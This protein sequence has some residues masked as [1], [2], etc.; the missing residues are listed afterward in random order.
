M[1][2][3]PDDEIE[4]YRDHA[5]ECAAY[6][7]FDRPDEAPW[8]RGDRYGWRRE[9][10]AW[11]HLEK[12][13]TVGH[14]LTINDRCCYLYADSAIATED[15]RLICANEAPVALRGVS[16]AEGMAAILGEGRPTVSDLRR[17]EAA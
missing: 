14:W 15:Y 13:D 2:A 1:G 11:V 12:G 3:I 5:S 9:D 17:A 6:L 4:T 10:V 16:D 7:L 8:V